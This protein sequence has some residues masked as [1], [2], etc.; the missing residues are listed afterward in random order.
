MTAFIPDASIAGLDWQKSSY[1]GSNSNCVETS[2]LEARTLVRDSKSPDG[3]ALPFTNRAWTAFTTEVK[4][5]A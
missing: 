4:R 5:S 2:P 3:P 1:S